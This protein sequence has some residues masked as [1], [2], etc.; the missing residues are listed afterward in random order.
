LTAKWYNQGFGTFVI[1]TMDGHAFT[2]GFQGYSLGAN[3]A[4]AKNIVGNVVYYDT[5]SKATDATAKTI[6]SELDFTF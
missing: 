2:E 1:H 3:Y 5:K 6:W 4:F